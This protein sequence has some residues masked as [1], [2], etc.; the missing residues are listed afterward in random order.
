MTSC[1]GNGEV[2]MPGHLGC[3]ISLAFIIFI[4][5]SASPHTLA[6]IDSVNGQ[7]ILVET[8]TLLPTSHC[9]TNGNWDWIESFRQLDIDIS[10][11]KY[12]T[13]PCGKGHTGASTGYKPK[14]VAKE[15]YPSQ[16][17]ELQNQEEKTHFIYLYN[18]YHNIPVLITASF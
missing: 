13:G 2:F 7:W 1:G 17:Q 16:Q 18:I 14:Y 10:W 3:R 15:N 11:Y 8:P 6:A 9:R 4:G 5:G 12:I